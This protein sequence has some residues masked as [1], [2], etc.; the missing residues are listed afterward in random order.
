MNVYGGVKQHRIECQKKSPSHSFFSYFYSRSHIIYVLV[1]L[2]GYFPLPVDFFPL[3]SHFFPVLIKIFTSSLQ[4]IWFKIEL[5]SIQTNAILDFHFRYF[6]FLW[7]QTHTHKKN[8]ISSL[9]HKQF[10]LRMD[11][12]LSLTPTQTHARYNNNNN[13]NNIA[14]AV[15]EAAA[16]ATTKQKCNKHC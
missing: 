13:N 7:F 12:V 9:W 1:T 5:R 3:F 11:F 15:A 6:L 14:A 16:A 10:T 2:N 8:E 4:F